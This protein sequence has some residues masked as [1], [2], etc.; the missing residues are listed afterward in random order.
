MNNYLEYIYT[1]NK[2]CPEEKLFHFELLMMI[3]L[4]AL[5]YPSCKLKLIFLSVLNFNEYPVRKDRRTHC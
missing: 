5:W 3:Y 4:S 2:Y 1:Y